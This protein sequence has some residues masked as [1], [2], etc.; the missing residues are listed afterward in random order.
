MD[1]KDM[2]IVFMGTPEFA[3]ESLKALV[4]GGYNVV[5]VVTQPDK[6][7]GRHQETLQPPAVKV[8][9]ESVGLP[10]LQPI[11]MKDTEFLEQLRALNADLQVV[12]AFRMLPEVV[13][14]MPRFGTFNVHASLLPQ[15][16][17]AA[18]INWAVIN[19]ETETGV[20]TF[21]LDKD[22]D[23]GRIIKRKYFPIPDSANVEYVYDGLMRLG[24]ELA[25]ET[26]DLLCEKV[27][28]DFD[29]E[30]I[31]SVKNEITE[32][33]DESSDLRHAPKIFKETCE[34]NWHQEAI[35]IYNFVRG[36]SPYP[37]A[38]S[39]MV[40]LDD[41]AAPATKMVLKIFEVAKT[42]KAVIAEPGTFTV[43]NKK[44]YV[45]TNDF[46]LELKEL[47]LSGKKRMDSRSFL[48]GFKQVEEYRLEKE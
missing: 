37:G 2:R 18:P 48:N 3:I 25:I 24:A 19:G 21:F 38:W 11:K 40:S 16:R 28:D 41:A 31:L 43:E 36:L 15:Y 29:A 10:V 5:G 47:Q 26:I 7:V 1:K 14:S 12:V 42:E 22:I 9:A 46:L 6:P 17:G 27:A 8:Y 34:I 39:K 33:Q 45:N 23:T 35:T 30:K 4:E 20:T 13:W 44:V 32:A